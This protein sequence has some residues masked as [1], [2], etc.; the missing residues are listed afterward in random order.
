MFYFAARF[1]GILS[2][3]VISLVVPHHGGYMGT[4]RPSINGCKDIA[5]YSYGSS[6]GIPTQTTEN[7]IRSYNFSEKRT[8]NTTLGDYK[9]L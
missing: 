1:Y 2:Y 5:V 9:T 6:L 3:K 7:I 4:S 8:I